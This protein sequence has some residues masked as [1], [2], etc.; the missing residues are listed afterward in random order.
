MHEVKKKK[1]RAPLEDTRQ[2]NTEKGLEGEQRNTGRDY[3][4][5]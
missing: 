4:N 3:T 1:I 2:R 5:I